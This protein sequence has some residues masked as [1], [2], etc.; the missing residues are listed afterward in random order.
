MTGDKSSPNLF[1]YECRNIIA[2]VNTVTR[3]EKMNL[4]ILTMLVIAAVLVS[5]CTQVQEKGAKVQ[6]SLLVYSSDCMQSAM[7]EIGQKFEQERGIKVEY[8]F[9]GSGPLWKEITQWKQGD[10]FISGS[11]DYAEKAK[12]QGYFETYRIVAYHKMAIII[13]KDNPA[14]IKGLHD[15]TNDSVRVVMG[16]PRVTAMGKLAVEIFKEANISGGILDNNIV[17]EESNCADI[18]PTLLKEK[19]DVAVNCIGSTYGEDNVTLI[20]IPSEVNT[21]KIP[22][23]VLTF[24]NNKEMANQ[25]VDFVVSDEGK[26]LFERYGFGP[27]RGE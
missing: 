26:A 6:K 18:V 1:V 23:G 19:I 24:S 5:G 16:D 27:L 8:V 20:D 7:L 11:E 2:A 22:I 13:P 12:G 25:F 17:L 4:K 14:G 10:V 9:G 15:L 3:K 21:V